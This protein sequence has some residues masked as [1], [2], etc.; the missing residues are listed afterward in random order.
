MD[1]YTNTHKQ[2]HRRKN[3]QARVCGAVMVSGIIGFMAIPS[4]VK[5]IDYLKLGFIVTAVLSC[6]I[7]LAVLASK[8][9]LDG[10]AALVEQVGYDKLG[11]QVAADV[12]IN[13]EETKIRMEE[14]LAALMQ[15]GGGNA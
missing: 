13:N 6:P 8:K 9:T 4:Q 1:F 10:K 14:R 11:A 2:L 3:L 5:K 15:E 12:A 7:G